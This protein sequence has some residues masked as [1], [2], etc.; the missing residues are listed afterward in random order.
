M[1]KF[2]DLFTKEL[3]AIASKRTKLGQSRDDIQENLVGIALSG[4]G[5]RSATI[6]LGFL[7]VMNKPGLLKQADYISSVSGGGYIGSYIHS[8]LRKNTS[9]DNPYSE[10]FL[11]EDIDHFRNHGKYLTPSKNKISNYSSLIGGYFVTA[12]L[13]LIWYIM[14]ALFVGYLMKWLNSNTLLNMGNIAFGALVFTAAYYYFFRIVRIIPKIGTKLWSPKKLIIAEG[15]FALIAFIVYLFNIADLLPG[16]STAQTVFIL[17]AATLFLGLFA[18]PNILSSHMFYNFRLK[19]AYLWFERTPSKIYEL[20]PGSSAKKWGS[21]PYPL[22]N[23]T[24]NLM[25]KDNYK[26]LKSCDYFLFSPF[27]SGSKLTG[28]VPTNKSEYKNISLSTAMTISGAAVNSNMG[29]K[30]NRFLAFFM[31][32]LNI[33]LGY[34]ALNPKIITKKNKNLIEKIA[35]ACANNFNYWPTFWPYCNLA[36][37]F[38]LPTLKRWRINISDGGHIENMGA[39]ELLKRRCKLI[40]A[41]DAG[42]DPEYEF[43]D[44]KNLVIRARN[45]LGLEIKFRSEPEDEIKPKA[46][47]GFSNKHYCVADIYELPALPQKLE[48]KKSNRKPIGTFVYI[49]SSMMA[50]KYKSNQEYKRVLEVDYLKKNFGGMYN[51]F[52]YKT[53]HPAFPHEPTVD[54]FFDKDQWDAYYYLGRSMGSEVLKD[55]KDILENAKTTRLKGKK[56]SD[57]EIFDLFNVLK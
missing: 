4:G 41:V 42:A 1:K 57:L 11:K 46:S 23:T 52:K 31:T 27:Y 29:Y 50:P 40:I 25:G 18:N 28:Y 20:S 44:L 39:Y 37:L 55:I 10:L 34:W 6:N 17:G 19:D 45:E 56:I 12:I 51:A 15:L 22:I 21:A 35:Y 43:A 49:K 36:E 24:L 30:S 48:E 26:G 47:S 3:E 9:A 32:L 14:F 16:S 2:E 33:R 13:H 7:Q 53:Y 8:K 5:V 38:G 54:Q